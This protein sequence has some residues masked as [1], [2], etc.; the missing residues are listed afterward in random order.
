M[1]WW[2]IDDFYVEKQK[3]KTIEKGSIVYAPVVYIEQK[4][5]ILNIERATVDYQTHSVGNISI[6]PL[7]FDK[8]FQNIAKKLPVYNLD[9]RSDEELLINRSKMRPCV[10][11]HIDCENIQKARENDNGVI[12]LNNQSALLLPIYGFEKG[13]TTIPKYDPI[14]VGRIMCLQY[15][16]LFFFPKNTIIEEH[17]VITKDSF[18]RFDMV[19]NLPSA[20]I[21]PTHTK[22]SGSYTPL[23]DLYLA[24]YLKIPMNVEILEKGK[25]LLDLA[26]EQ[27]ASH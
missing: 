18:G 22:I 6:E 2:E 7:D 11:L 21:Y 13:Q 16:K 20:Y 10:V 17:S 23:L 8:H 25:V 27:C 19:F 12:T 3:E 15:E 9:L 26:Q 4:Q 14:T 24:N 5:K 1:N